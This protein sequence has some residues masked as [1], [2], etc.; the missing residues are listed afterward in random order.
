VTCG[1]L[2]LGKGG[3]WC[4]DAMGTREERRKQ[5]ARRP[6]LLRAREA[7][8]AA[9]REAEREAVRRAEAEAAEKGSV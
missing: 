4:K 7:W 6:A 8:W 2:A 9:R 5:E 1:V 3:M